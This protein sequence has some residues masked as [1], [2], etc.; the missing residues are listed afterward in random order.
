[1]NQQTNDS[2]TKHPDQ[3]VESAAVEVR[4]VSKVFRDF[5]RRPKVRAVQ[6]ITFQVPHGQVFGLLGPN[7]SGKS[8]TMKMLLGLLKPTTGDLRVLSLPP[9]DVGAKQRIG[10]MPEH[11]YVYP[12]LTSRETLHF[13]G[14]L[15]N[16]SS[17]TIK[18]RTETLLHVL[19]LDH[20]A[21]RL[22]GE[23]SKGMA[24]R[25]GLAQALINNPDI[26][27]LDEPTAGLDPIG[28]RHFK[29]FIQQLAANGKTVV[30]CSHLLSDVEDV[31]DAIAILYRGNL[32]AQGHM[33]DLLHTSEGADSHRNL[34]SFFLHQIEAA[35][36]GASGVSDEGIQA[37]FREFLDQ[38]GHDGHDA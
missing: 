20:A 13:Y 23:F 36:A 28:C 35:R 30:L 31:C 37:Q 22:V 7:G 24:R 18:R 5:W 9:S 26:L 6:D 27:F 15:F 4:H 33:R 1:M 25:V 21:D 2:K 14:R 3:T 8:T 10:Y 19:E 29:D 38:L 17:D 16:L 32:L 34:E 12:Y 11:S